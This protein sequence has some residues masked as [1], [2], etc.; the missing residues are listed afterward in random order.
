MEGGVQKTGGGF[1]IWSINIGGITK[2]KVE[3]ARR[4]ARRTGAEVIL[5][6]ETWLGGERKTQRGKRAMEAAELQMGRGSYGMVAMSKKGA[7]KGGGGLG[8]AILV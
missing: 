2:I 8:T 4:E 3:M 6:Q 1:G 7:G 5:L